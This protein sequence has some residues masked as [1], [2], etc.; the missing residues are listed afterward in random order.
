LTQAPIFEVYLRR[1]I[2][3]R[4]AIEALDP[5]PL[6]KGLSLTAEPIVINFGGMGLT[7]PAPIEHQTD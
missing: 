3:Q 1:Q 4:A 2:S 6:L 5:P 7:L